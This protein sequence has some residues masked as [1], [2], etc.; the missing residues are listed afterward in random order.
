MHV[1]IS[2]VDTP[3]GHNLSRHF[4]NA[5]PPKHEEEQGEEVEQQVQD[6]YKVFGSLA[7][8]LVINPDS[9]D[10]LLGGVSVAGAMVYTG[11]KKRDKERQDAI[12]KFSVCGKKPDWVKDIVDVHYINLDYR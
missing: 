8:T 9:P 10:T 11:D 6:S 2:N 4:A 1:F 5:P 7:K 3:T 12:E